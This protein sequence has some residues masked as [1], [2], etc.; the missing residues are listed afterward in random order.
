M[1]C[2]LLGKPAF[3]QKIRQNRRPIRRRTRKRRPLDKQKLERKR[4]SAHRLEPNVVRHNPNLY[5]NLRNLYNKK[6]AKCAN[7]QRLKTKYIFMDPINLEC[8]DED[9]DIE[10]YE[11]LDE[12]EYVEE[13]CE[14]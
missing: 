8:G 1:D 3:S 2:R 9:L 12:F 6:E 13:D 7:S 5:L 10:D 14:Y 4:R 11:N